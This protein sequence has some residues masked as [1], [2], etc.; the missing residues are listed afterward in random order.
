MKI[1]IRILKKKKEDIHRRS[2]KNDIERRTFICRLC[3]KSYLSYP[4]L[5]THRKQKH[6]ITLSSGREG[7]KKDISE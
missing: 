2:S 6:N 4:A 1:T 5:Y 3:G 7:P